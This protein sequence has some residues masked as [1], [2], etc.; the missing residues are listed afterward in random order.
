VKKIPKVKVLDCPT[1]VV[2][3]EVP[4]WKSFDENE[5]NEI[6]EGK[7]DREPERVKEFQDELAKREAYLMSVITGTMPPDELTLLGALS[8]AVKIVV[9]VGY[10][11]FPLILQAVTKIYNSC[12]P[13]EKVEM[14]Q[15][16][17]DDDT[18]IG[19]IMSGP[20]V[21]TPTTYH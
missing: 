5:R 13:D 7:L 17:V 12:S 1:E 11:S 4:I 19:A 15:C 16:Q 10:K 2:Q 20:K 3:V 18:T 9:F 8:A 21:P 14:R 6:G